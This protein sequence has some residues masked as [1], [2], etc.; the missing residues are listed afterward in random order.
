LGGAGGVGEG[1]G[2][3][4]AGDLDVGGVDVVAGGAVEGADEVVGG[5]AV[6]LFVAW[7]WRSAWAPSRLAREAAR[8]R[9]RVV[10][11]W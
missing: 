6:D 7:A 5:C 10:V 8:A 3:G 1:D 2:G 4:V 11:A 9:S